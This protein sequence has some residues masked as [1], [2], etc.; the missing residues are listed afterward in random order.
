LEIFFFDAVSFFFKKQ[1][2]SWKFDDPCQILLDGN[3]IDFHQKV[4]NCGLI[5]NKPDI[6]N[7]PKLFLHI[8]ATLANV[9]VHTIV[10]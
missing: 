6:E 9:T 7:M 4:K 1:K 2:S 3:N 5:M 10:P 8:E